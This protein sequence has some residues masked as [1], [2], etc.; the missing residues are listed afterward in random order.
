MIDAHI[1]VMFG[2]F[3]GVVVYFI[4]MSIYERIEQ[5]RREEWQ[6]ASGAREAHEVRDEFLRSY[7]E[8]LRRGYSVVWFSRQQQERVNWKSE[9]F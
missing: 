8:T 1:I 7:A 4:C 9:G 3:T 2:M 5:K 6:R